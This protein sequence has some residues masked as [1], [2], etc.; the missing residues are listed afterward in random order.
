MNQPLPLGV[1]LHSANRLGSGH[2]ARAARLGHP[3]QLLGAWAQGMP[4]LSLPPGTEGRAPPEYPG[5]P[6]LSL[7]LSDLS[8]LGRP[9]LCKKPLSPSLSPTLMPTTLV[10]T[11][12]SAHSSEK[13][14]GFTQKKTREASSP[15]TTGLGSSWPHLTAASGGF[16]EHHGAAVGVS[17]VPEV[18]GFQ[19]D[20]SM[21][22][23]PSKP[24]SSVG[25][26]KSLH[27]VSQNCPTKGSH[28]LLQDQV[29]RPSAVSQS[30]LSL[31]RHAKFRRPSCGGRLACFWGLGLLRARLATASHPPG[32]Q[33]LCRRA[34]P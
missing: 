5:E 1:S 13:A 2:P 26:V 8:H 25:P 9:S 33:V 24:L 20:G 30:S 14:E 11:A 6:A 7:P 12:G 34:W 15:R 18:Q 22:S 19:H 10:P 17:K 23:V 29:P 27:W 4:P 28:A 31:H 21:G 3:L 16:E 32:Q